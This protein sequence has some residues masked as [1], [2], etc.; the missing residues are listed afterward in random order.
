MLSSEKRLC[1][2][3]SDALVK[4][5]GFIP[6]TVRHT[7]SPRLTG[8]M[9]GL[10][11]NIIPFMRPACGPITKVRREGLVAITAGQAAADGDGT[12]TTTG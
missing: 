2:R 12:N 8:V 10:V 11:P 7:I 5:S 6:I 9:K 1:L 4:A 3:R